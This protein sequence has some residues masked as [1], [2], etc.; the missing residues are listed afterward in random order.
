MINSIFVSERLITDNVLVAHELMTHTNRK[1]KGKNEE[2]AL[3]LDMSKVYDRVKWGCLKLIM[4]K[5]GFHEDWIRLV[6]RCVSSVTYAVRINGHPWGQ[7]V[8]TRGLHQGNPL[9]LYLFLI[10]AEG[11]SAL[12]HKAV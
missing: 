6:M 3:R 8:P 4:T 7:I 12:L 10:C 11:L 5:L 9:S 1:K 2:M